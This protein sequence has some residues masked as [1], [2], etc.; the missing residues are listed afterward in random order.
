MQLTTLQAK[1]LAHAVKLVTTI[2]DSTTES[3][4]IDANVEIDL[5]TV[6]LEIKQSTD[7]IP[8]TEDAKGI[9]DF[10][11]FTSI[12]ITI[13]DVALNGDIWHHDASFNF[14]SPFGVQKWYDEFMN[15]VTVVDP[16]KRPVKK[17]VK[18]A[19]KKVAVK[20]ATKLH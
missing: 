9:P 16:P 3:F 5:G 20:R 7:P 15:T 11:G 4:A 8:G 12:D 19:V 6:L 1:D 10:D 17:A 14:Y 18:K 2:L 13:Y